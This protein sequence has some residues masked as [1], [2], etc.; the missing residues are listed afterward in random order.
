MKKNKYT[1]E[2][3]A[4]RCEW[5]DVIEDDKYYEDDDLFDN[6]L[7]F[8]VY[9]FAYLNL[10]A[11]TRAQ[12]EMAQFISDKNHPH[13]MLMALRGLSKSLTAQ[14]YCAWRLLND[15]NEHILV[16]SA[17]GKRAENFTRFVQKLF[18]ILP[19]LKP[20]KPRNN[21][22]RTS[23]TSFD[24]VGADISDS[25]SVYAV[26]VENQ[27]SGFR[28]TLVIYDDIESPQT[29]SSAVQREKIDYYASEAANLLISGRDESITLCTPHSMDS[30]YIDW[31]LKGFKPFVIPAEY[32]ESPDYYNDWLAPY[33]AD[34]LKKMPS[35]A[36]E[37]VD[38]RFP[39]EVLRSKEM[40]LGKSQYRLQ[41][42]LDTSIS[43]ELKHP[44]KLSDLIIYDIDIDEAPTKITY[45]SMPDKQLHIKHNGFK[46]DKIY[47]PAFVSDDKRN[48]EKRYMS[49]DPAGKGSDEL[50]Y[51]IGY[52][53]LGRIFIKDIG[54]IKGGGYEADTLQ[55]IA[56]IA[57][58]YKVD[59]IILESNFGGG[60]FFNLLEPYIDRLKQNIRIESVTASKQKEKRIIETLEPLLNQ[61]KIIIDKSIF[62][63][64]GSN[65]INY[66]FTYQLSH[67]SY[68]HDCLVHDDR[69]DSL[70]QLCEFAGE[71]FNV[72]EEEILRHEEESQLEEIY[73]RLT[74]E[75]YFN[76]APSFISRF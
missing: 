37:P 72:I 49:I 22:E 39:K 48:Y 33:L 10:P 20:M 26:G 27:I 15:P 52:T 14:L 11:P 61:H 73:N 59:I 28:A 34:R 65:G 12:L 2:Y 64:D 57:S 17:T 24:V 50:A 42:N 5:G 35:L 76:V 18:T 74:N 69:L 32:P 16:M 36:G 46:G 68:E 55:G 51:T 13:R 45:S 30:I 43:D 1:L 9:A 70:S 6:F 4:F 25:P 38:E 56:Q 66:S 71:D 29:A 47:A 7:V 53:S 23:T 8:Y 41:Y 62:D 75:V 3:F 63:R 54:G 31:I 58:K 60:M 67:I 40:R 44:L 19:V 21:K